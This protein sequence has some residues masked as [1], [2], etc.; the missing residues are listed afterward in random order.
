[1]LEKL[2]NGFG[3]GRNRAAEGYTLFLRTFLNRGYVDYIEAKRNTAMVES[4]EQLAG[5]VG[6]LATT[7]SR[8]SNDIPDEWFLFRD[9]MFE[10]ERGLIDLEEGKADSE[11]M[12]DS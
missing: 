10:F 5:I 4:Q 7:S 3:V 9:Q 2:T 1:M 11:T 12:S 6:R 8:L